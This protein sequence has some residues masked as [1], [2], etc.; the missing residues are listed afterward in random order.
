MHF[1]LG[2]HNDKMRETSMRSMKSKIRHEI[3]I[4]LFLYG[5]LTYAFFIRKSHQKNERNLHEKYEIE[6]TP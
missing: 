4:T 3:Q 6:N 5:I 2:N 1:L